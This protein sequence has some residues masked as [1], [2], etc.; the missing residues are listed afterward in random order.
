MIHVPSARLVVQTVKY[1]DGAVTYPDHATHYPD[2]ETK[3]ADGVIKDDKDHVV[4]T[5]PPSV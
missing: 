1:G 2:G 3:Y 4:G 5:A